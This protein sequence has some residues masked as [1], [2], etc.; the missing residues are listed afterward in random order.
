MAPPSEAAKFWPSPRR[1]AERERPPTP[2]TRRSGQSCSRSQPIWSCS[3]WTDIRYQARSAGEDAASWRPWGR[4]GGCL[5][6]LCRRLT[7]GL[8]GCGALGG[9][10]MPPA[11]ATVRVPTRNLRRLRG[12]PQPARGHGCSHRNTPDSPSPQ[13]PTR[14]APQ[15]GSSRARQRLGRARV[16][17]RIRPACCS[18]SRWTTC[19]ADEERPGVGVLDTFSPAAVRAGSRPEML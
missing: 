18:C 5:K 2:P 8:S 9:R 19:I 6:A 7:F 4:R 15:K 10:W 13:R 17:S 11:A 16:R 14:R 3:G 12:A 1:P